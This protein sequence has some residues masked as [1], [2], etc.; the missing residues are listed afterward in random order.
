MAVCFPLNQAAIGILS[1]IAVVG[2]A[3]TVVLA[4][5]VVL[6][7]Y[8]GRE[9]KLSGGARDYEHPLAVPGKLLV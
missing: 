2:I 6:V 4:G 7:V 9:K 8:R 1:A 5:L 3:A